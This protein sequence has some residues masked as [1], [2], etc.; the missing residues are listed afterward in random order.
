MIPF[1]PGTRHPRPAAS[2]GCA[3]TAARRPGAPATARLA[4][5]PAARRKLNRSRPA[6]S[7]RPPARMAEAGAIRVARSA[8]NRP[9]SRQVPT[10]TAAVNRQHAQVE[11]PSPRTP[12][13]RA[14]Q[15]S[16][17]A[18]L[19]TCAT[20]APNAVPAKAQQQAF[21]QQLRDQPARDAP[22]AWRTAIS[23]S[24]TLARASSRFARLAQAIRSTRPVVASSSQS[25]DPYWRRSADTPV[26]P[27]VTSSLFA[28]YRFR[29][30]GPVRG[31]KGV[32]HESRR[33][34][35]AFGHWRVP[36]S[37]PA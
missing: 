26:A 19:S 24:R 12:A 10:A 2:A 34:R 3:Q 18:R 20:S 5:P 1:R 35:S 16:D 9:N 29:H 28:R 27:R 13:L 21:R 30:L 11:F 4:P 32:V 36:S 37:I 33:E 15:E 17:Q 6:V 8:G 23:R 25:G 31:R 7:P 14:A 22:I